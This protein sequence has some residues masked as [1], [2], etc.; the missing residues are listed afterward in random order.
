[1]KKYLSIVL[2]CL[3][4]FGFA[5]TNYVVTFKVNAA[6]ITVGSNG[7][8]LGGGVIGGANA[9]QLTDADGNGVYEGTDTLSGAG[10]GNFIFLNSPT[11]NGDWGTK[12]NLAGLACADANNYNDRILPS[13]TQDTTLMFCYGTCS[14]DTLC[15]TTYTATSCGDLFF[16]EY[17]EGSS[18]NKYFEIYNPT[19]SAISLSGYTVYLSGNGGSYTNTFTSS[20]SIASGDVYMISTNQ[21]DSATQA[22]AD[23]AMGYPSVA[24]FNGD[25]ALILV[26]GTDTIDVIGVPGVD[27]GSSWTVGTGST[28]NHTLVRKATVDMGSTDWTTGAGEWDVYASNTWTYAGSN[29]S[30]CIVTPKNVTF[31]VDMSNVST[32]FT[33]VYV[34]GTVN[35]W[36]GNSN[37]LTDADGDG[38]YEGTLSLMPGSYEYKFT[39]DNWTGQETL[40]PVTDATCTLTT[41][42]FTNRY[43]TIGNADTTLPV[44]CWESCNTCGYV[45]PCSELYF[46]EYAEGSSNNKYFEIYNPTASAISLSGYTVYLSGNGGSY[47]NTF[48][49]SA[50]I[51]SGDVYMISTNQL[52][53]A[54]QTLADTAMGYPSVAHFN[55]DDALILVNGTDTIDVIGVPGVDPG[56]SWTVGTGST[57][58]HTLVRKATVD[59]GSTDWT[60]GAGEWDVYASNTWTYAGS[61]SSNCIVTPKN[62]TFQVDMSNVSASFTNV[63][64]S[65]TLNNWSGNSNQLTDADGDGV[66]EGTLSL[67]PGSYEYKFTYDNWTSQESLDPNSADSTCTLTT[68]GFTNRYS[69]F[70]NADTTLPVVCWEECSACAP[71]L[72]QVCGTINLELYDSYGDGWNGAEID[73][74]FTGGDSTYTLSS[75]S[76][77]SIPLSI[78]YLDTANFVWAADGS[79]PSECTFKITDASGT[80][81]YS[82]PTGSVMTVGAAQYTTY[83]AT[84]PFPQVC[85]TINLELYDSYGDGWNGAEIDVEF[86]GGDSTYTLSS[87][88]YVSI[89]LS[90]NYLD[91]ANFVWAADGSYPSECTYKITDASGTVLYSSPTGSVMTVGTAQYTTYCA[92]L[93]LPQ[94]CG[95]LFFSEYSE[96]SSNN[97]YIEIYN[98]TANAV[99]LSTYTVYQSG[100]GGSFTNT[101]TTNATLASGDVYMIATNQADASIQ[102]VAD[103]VLAF[104]SIAHFNGDDAM[105]LVSGTDTVDVIGVPGVDPGSSWTVGT[106]S[107]ANHTL[108]RMASIGAGSTD[109]TTGATEWDVYAQNTWTYMG[110]H[111]SNCIYVA[112]APTFDSVVAIN[113]ITGVDA[114]GVADSLG[115]MKWIKGI[116]T[117]IDFDGNGGYSFYVTDGTDGIN[118]YNFADQSGYTTP[119]MGDSLFLHGEVDQFNGLTELFVDSIYLANSGNT[120]PAPA[121]VTAL[122]ESTESELIQLVGFTLADATQWPASGSANVDITNGTDT[123]TMRIDSDTDIDSS[124]APAGT[125]DVT[126]IGS[127]YDSS[128]PYDEGYQIFP[129]Q[130]TDIFVYPFIP[131]Y[132][133]DQVDNTDADGVPDSLNV[134]C[135]VVGVVHGVDMQGSATAVSFTVHDG[136][137]GLGTY[138]SVATVASYVVTEGDEVRIVGSIGHFN[139]L[140]Q[141]YVD[142][143]TVLSTGNATQ[144]PTV[145]TAL[146]ESTESE[147]VK[148][149]NMTMVDP[150]QWGSGSSGYNIDITNGSDTIVMRIDADVDLYGAPAPT[151][152]FDVVG[153]GGQYDFSAPH[154]DGYQLLPRYQADIMTSTGVAAVKLSISEIMAGSNS[155]AYNADWFEI[156]NYGDSAVDLNGYS[157][158]DESEIAGTSTFPAVTVQPGE[159]IVV[160]DDVAANKDAFLAEW[161][162]YAGSV[163]IVANDELTGSFPSLSQNGDAVFLYD[164]NGA[165]MAS[166]VYSAATA[167]FAVEFD[168]TGAFLGDAV[169]GTNGAYTSLEGD[170]GSPGNLTPNTG[171]DEASVISN[172]YPNPTTGSFT[173]NLA[174]DI[175]YEA[176]ITNMTGA[177]VFHKVGTGSVLEIDLDAARG[178]YVLRVRTAQGTAVQM[179]VLQ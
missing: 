165:E 45:A 14:T 35:N 164:A 113:T 92:T 153:I 139:G 13:F 141:M 72:P 147:L 31:Q 76:Y 109:W 78:N 105:I 130:L 176:T 62:V 36:S 8:Y 98:P 55:G 87:G 160:L 172:I 91:T 28:A 39:Y 106:G 50:S 30:N 129:R 5:Q 25:D 59:M 57:A 54:T 34:S 117:S 119:M 12:E 7:I 69:T 64:V 43:S 178:T 80:V 168:T 174:S 151:G 148:F 29:S 61:N 143:I 156:H 83:C 170:V 108:V 74:E 16:S 131:T 9:V 114:S 121:V 125:F 99:S 146:G 27:P 101:F 81:L 51:A 179:I 158:D 169:D 84:A 53:S 73:V 68:F 85:G 150:T 154:F 166:G 24:H 111:T 110:A 122:D 96:G 118:I 152:M 18:N 116:V 136:T 26:N 126:G 90:V 144:T 167:G 17:A 142:S 124:T 41:G 149:E 58:N 177:A 75:G 21:L 3:S 89:P 47:T 100:N 140:L 102:A 175:S 137:E 107:T 65:G 44:V 67:M 155:T 77:I 97:K 171:V 1:M 10:G 33:N 173:V 46:S 40:D 132:T 93:P 20:A 79:Y 157:W 163:T 104:P 70:G 48:T 95:E 52:D 123:M 127:Q 145:V 32:S 2:V 112:P 23:T 120:L 63:Y 94:V 162:L 66:Y 135:K 60:T 38:V 4:Y 37:Q 88:S 82:S 6:N 42:A 161:K 128:S 15:T 11:W 134:Y 56:S 115:T 159:A 138:S 103:T 19:A 86:T 22:M 71:A 133:I 49:S